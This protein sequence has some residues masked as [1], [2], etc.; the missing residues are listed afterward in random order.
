MSAINHVEG[1]NVQFQ[2]KPISPSDNSVSYTIVVTKDG[3]KISEVGTINLDESQEF[4]NTNKNDAIN[5]DV[6]Q[7]DAEITIPS[8]NSDNHH[9]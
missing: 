4:Y 2:L 9:C 3:K 7:K 6:S 8:F 1:L 5:L